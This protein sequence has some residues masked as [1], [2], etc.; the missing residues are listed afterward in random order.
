M[1]WIG[2]SGFNWGSAGAGSAWKDFD[3]VYTERYAE[4]LGFKKPI[5]LTEVAAPESGGDKA[6]WITDT[7]AAIA[8]RYPRVRAVIW[9][10]KFD[11][12]DR[13][14]RI[15]S[16]PESAAAFKAAVGREPYAGAPSA[17]DTATRES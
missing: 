12:A 11:F 8:D 5:A 9:Y 10:D 14:W 15:A 17:L 2:I 7:Y 3:S 4:L 16:S 1:D 6:A 13:D